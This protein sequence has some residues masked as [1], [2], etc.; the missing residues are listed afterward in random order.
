MRRDI[1]KRLTAVVLALA[2]G[3]AAPAYGQTAPRPSNAAELSAALEST[4][5]QV[6]PAVVEIFATSFAPG[7]GLVPRTFEIVGAANLTNAFGQSVALAALAAAT[8]W[9]LSKSRW[10]SVRKRST[11]S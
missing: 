10:R 1:R 3:A 5:R 7:E 8:L 6:S 9:P 2:L 11:H 4:T